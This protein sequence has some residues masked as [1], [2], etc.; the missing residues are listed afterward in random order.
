MQGTGIR[1]FQV[2]TEEV[3]F[4][5]EIPVKIRYNC[6]KQNQEQNMKSGTEDRIS[7]IRKGKRTMAAADNRGKRL[8][9][10]GVRFGDDGDQCGKG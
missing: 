2:K 9:K 4:R 5:V 10:C 1:F 7:D 3:K 6:R 8:S